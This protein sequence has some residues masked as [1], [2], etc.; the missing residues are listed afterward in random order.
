MTSRTYF[1]ERAWH[2]SAPT[3][4][5]PACK[6]DPTRRCAT[7]RDRRMVEADRV[8]LTCGEFRAYCTCKGKPRIARMKRPYR[9]KRG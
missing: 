4:P 7:C 9:G 3:V 1:Y 2:L 6:D 8:C 5:C